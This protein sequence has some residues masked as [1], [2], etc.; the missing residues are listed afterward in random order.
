MFKNVGQKAFSGATSQDAAGSD[1][2]ISLTS[3]ADDQHDSDD[4]FG[5]ENILAERQ[6]ENGEIHYLV[7]WS[8]F[9]QHQSTW[10]PEMNLGNELRAMWED[11]KR[12]HE[13]G[14][15]K[16][17]D[18]EAFYASQTKAKE[19]KA[20]RHRRRN[21]KRKKKR[22]SLTSTLPEP[23]PQGLGMDD[24]SEDDAAEDVYGEDVYGE[25]S[26]AGTSVK[27]KAQPKEKTPK[28]SAKPSGAS[29]K[30]LAST[31]D[32][33]K[34]QIE[35][36]SP[37]AAKQTAASNQRATP[38]SSKTLAERRSLTGYQGTA[39]KAAAKSP[40]G[41]AA[42]QSKTQTSTR[43]GAASSAR[44]ASDTQ[45]GHLTAKKSA[46][47]KR[48]S[49]NIFSGGTMRK[50]RAP[51]LDSISDPS[52]EPKLF[53][54]LRTRRLAEKRSRD[55]EDLAPNIS[56]LHF[57]GIGKGPLPRKS[58]MDATL[59]PGLQEPPVQPKF[60]VPEQ[61]SAA[62]PQEEIPLRKK[63]KSVRF[64]DDD[65]DISPAL[66]Q[67]PEPIDID[68]PTN[69][70]SP[71]APRGMLVRSRLRS[72]PPPPAENPV[73][74]PVPVPGPKKLSLATYRS[75]V[76]TQSL[77]K[78]LALGTSAAIKVDFNNM[79]RDPQQTWIADFTAKE[80]IEFHYQ[81]FA[82]TMVLKMDVLVRGHLAEGTITSEANESALT[83]AAEYLR[84]GV[85]GLFCSQPEYNIIIYPTKCDEWRVDS[86]GQEP[87]SP[88]GI[89]L[90]YLIFDSEL[91]CGSLLRP[92]NI[93]PPIEKPESATE[94]KSTTEL[95][96]A[97][98]SEREAILRRLFNFSY[99]R[100]LPAF[101]KRP[102]VH[103]FFLA[104]PQSK[105]T[106]MQALYHWLRA[107]NPK[108]QIFSSHH[109][110]S[111]AAFWAVGEKT[112]GVIIIHESLAW[113][114]HRFPEL[115]KYLIS[116]YD[117]YWC[118]SE[119]NQAYPLYPSISLANGPAAP[120][121]LRLTR[122]FPART[123]IFL[124]PSFLVSEPLHA[125]EILEW[126]LTKW[127][128]GYTHRLVAA[129]NIHEYLLELAV[130]KS[131]AY[132][133][134]LGDRKTNKISNI[135]FQLG[136][137]LRG[138]TSVD[139]ENRFKAATVATELHN[140]RLSRTGP[141]G[142][143]ED[144][145]SL[146]YAD[147]AID[148]NDEQSLV[149]WFGWWSSLR[150]DQFQKFHVVGSS[151][152][153]EYQGCR[154]GERRIRIPRYSHVT[155]NDPDLVLQTIQERARDDLA[156][157]P[158]EGNGSLPDAPPLDNELDTNMSTQ[159]TPWSFRSEV[160]RTDDSQEITNHLSITASVPG[161]F[162]WTLYRFPVSWADMQMADHFGDWR[163]EY[164]RI[165]DWFKF[166][167]SFIDQK[168]RPS[169]YNTYVG[170]F[171]TITEDWDPQAIPKDPKPK[172]HAWLAIYRPV[173]PH[174][175]P[176]TKCEVIIWDPMARSRFGDNAPTEKGLLDMQRRV[177]Q[178]VREYGS[179]KNPGTYLEQVWLGGFDPPPECDPEYPFDTTLKFL[180]HL[181]RDL[182]KFLPAPDREM[183]NRG[184]RKVVLGDRAIPAPDKDDYSPNLEQSESAAMDLDSMDGDDGPED[185][186]TRII[187]HPPR[188]IKMIPGQRSKCSNKLYED[189]R[190]VKARGAAAQATHMKYT[191]T[192]TMT[193][194][195]EQLA[196]GR[197]YEHINV[198]RWEHIFNF[199]K[200]GRGGSDGKDS[201]SSA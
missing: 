154:R 85:L 112:P 124:T 171:Y 187:F 16:P 30:T 3:T 102:T 66:V 177:I 199:F 159:E 179:E 196:E 142:A 73:P 1:D 38:A 139:C 62:V 166:T 80:T 21:A 186:D 95:K 174:K 96:S 94:V 11:T 64:L 197:G 15:L 115:H 88:A 193:W 76:L 172:R 93:F 125:L 40:S 25:E 163:N 61:T 77:G 65:D 167:W 170:F 37:S 84:S 68:M 120:G 165:S 109:A 141:Y 19:E 53:G 161:R 108:C 35:N 97:T 69:E 22:L 184:Y 59:S 4:E 160:C 147:Q 43:G 54:K 106:I 92:I 101:P 136:T 82:K 180:W 87:A 182:K 134:M 91:D 72:P 137:N 24:S 185:E 138:L 74:V 143:D 135:D 130:E 152:S 118:F 39:R 79:P 50:T 98:E 131:D 195:G 86:L 28:G 90:R 31:T 191:F 189:A 67:E 104:F 190:L 176:F 175:K 46:L 113:N 41:N 119:P 13:S 150:A 192:P 71:T 200:I 10:E 116:R 26:F 194:Y 133:K 75:K 70:G 83:N 148:A 2:D 181:L 42:G 149:N 132:D 157:S 57:F 123:A 155:L 100:L 81:C 144:N 56:S 34:S 48:P 14:E 107:C 151:E 60:P 158:V 49:G 188:G 7:E 32:S 128:K 27:S 169:G 127:G 198:T 8:G 173:N 145:S 110:G 20:E 146:V 105:G 126:F 52:K 122:L 58:S 51:L 129:W 121:D 178:Y 33:S 45:K 5:V 168:G 9:P 36:R 111:W 44:M 29:S 6:V 153:I 164:H 117:Q 103:N 162:Q 156:G 99:T 201:V 55:K 78:M 12:K 183:P 18:L 63:H 114:I 47:N 17:F 23:E 89:S 140:L